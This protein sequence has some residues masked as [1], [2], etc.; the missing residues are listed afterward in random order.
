MDEARRKIETVR[1]N[2]K[3]TLSLSHLD[4]TYL[5]PKL[6]LL[7]NLQVLYLGNNRLTSLPLA[8][9]NWTALQVLYLHNNQLT[10]LPP[11]VSNWTA[12]QVL[13][14]SDNQLTS[15]PPEVSN[16]TALRVLFLSFNRLASLPSAVQNWTAL[17]ELYINSSVRLPVEVAYWRSVERIGERNQKTDQWIFH[18]NVCEIGRFLRSRVFSLRF[19]QYYEKLRDLWTE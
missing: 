1:Q 8:V 5:P 12:L 17:Q 18:V 2:N 9:Q 16:W 14:L 3:T 4:L 10:S 15:L 7:S 13:S 11:E 19:P 6:F